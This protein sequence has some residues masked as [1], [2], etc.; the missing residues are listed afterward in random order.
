MAD[1]LLVVANEVFGK[2][3]EGTAL[4]IDKVAVGT[5]ADLFLA[6]PTRVDQTAQKVPREK[7]VSL[8]LVPNSKFYVQIAKIQPNEEVIIFNN[9]TAQGNKI[10]EYC[11]EQE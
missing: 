10:K 5:E 7:I 8:E 3:I 1:E 2:D 9:N 6:L 11:L 4:A